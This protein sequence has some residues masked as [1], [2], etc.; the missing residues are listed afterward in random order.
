MSGRSGVYLVSAKQSDTGHTYDNSGFQEKDHSVGYSPT[1]GVNIQDAPGAKPMPE[2]PYRGMGKEELLYFSSRPFWRRLRMGCIAIVLIGWLALVITV[3]ALVLAYPRCREPDARSWYQKEAVY[4]IY[5]PSFKDSNGDGIGDLKG[6]ESKLDYI[7]DLGF[8]IFSL[9]PFYSGDDTGASTLVA[10]FGAGKDETIVDH[11]SV[12]EVYGT[13]ADF[14]SLVA[15]AHDKG[16][17]VVIDFVPNQSSKNHPWFMDSVANNLGTKRNYYVWA[18]GDVVNPPN[19]WKSHYD[20]SAWT[21]DATRG[22]YYLHQ[23]SS[24][25][26]DLNLRSA[27]LR[28]ELESIL[29]FW[30]DR[31]VDGFNIRRPG[32]LYEDFD[33]RSNPGSGIN[34]ADFTPMYTSGQPEV[35]GLLEQ[36]RMLLQAHNKTNTEKLLMADI[37]GGMDVTR[38]YSYCDRSGV[39]MPLNVLQSNNDCRGTC[40]R[41]Y[42]D[43]W[44]EATPSGKWASWMGGDENKDRLASSFNSSFIDAF[45]VATFLLPG[46]PVLY[47]GDELGATGLDTSMGGARVSHARAI[48][49]WD[50]STHGGFCDNCTTMWTDVAQ[51]VDN[52]RGELSGLIKD[53]IALRG[54]QS[55]RV[56]EYAAAL[57]DEA[58]FSFVREFDGESG[59]LVAV[60]LSPDT[61]TRDFTGSHHTI[62]SEATVALSRGSS[63]AVDDDADTSKL[64][65]GPYGAVVVSWDYVAKEL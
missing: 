41:T 31:D 2:K 11:K 18:D 7:Q 52:S 60:N 28:D 37:D 53:L 1:N 58:V 30:L 6:V 34:Y 47:Y 5:V 3:V 25:T 21:L 29:K 10:D 4:R 59:Y 40:L 26:A 17:Y 63:Y 27:A 57:R 61:V 13:L 54:E 42:V 48:M 43:M 62:E 39:Q 14:D 55:F 51:T 56:G 38:M 64:E 49:P 65:I 8:N 24:D 35:Y 23:Y 46:T 45:T 50:N 16:M 44:M 20:G 15:A 33:L 36:W 32:F 12:G 9:S 19:N 22:L